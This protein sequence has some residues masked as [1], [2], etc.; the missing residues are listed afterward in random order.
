[1]SGEWSLSSRR[2]NY[3]CAGETVNSTLMILLPW[4]VSSFVD[5]SIPFYF[6]FLLFFFLGPHLQHMEVLGLGV[7]SGLQLP[8]CA[9]AMAT[10][11]PSWVCDLHH[12]LW[13]PWT[14]NP[15]SEARNWLNP[16]PH[17]HNVGFLTH[18]AT[19]G[20][21][22]PAFFIPLILCGCICISVYFS[23]YLWV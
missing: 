20:T 18:W 21:R 2:A 8:A 16:L 17:R 23:T 4:F 22:T 7:E 5:F 11:D 3:F 1:M 6:S 15:L 19:K 10:Q 13:Q 9:T 12:S 14:L